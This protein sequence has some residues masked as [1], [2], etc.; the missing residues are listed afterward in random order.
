MTKVK[1]RVKLWTIYAAAVVIII[2]LLSGCTFAG[3][4]DIAGGTS[5]N[6]LYIQDVSGTVGANFTDLEDCPDSYTGHGGKVVSVKSK[7]DGLE[8]TV[9]SSGDMLKST[10]DINTDDIVDN[11]EKLEGSTKSEVQT[12]SPQSHDTTHE[13]G[14]SDEID[15]TGLDGIPE[16]IDT[17]DAWFIPIVNGTEDDVVMMR[18]IIF[19]M[20]WENC[21]YFGHWDTTITGSASITDAGYNLLHMVTGT[22]AY[23]TARACGAKLGWFNF[24]GQNLL[25]QCKF[26]NDAPSSNAQ[27]WMKLDFDNQGDPTGQSAG[28]RIDGTAIK[29][30]VYDGSLDVTDLSITWSGQ[31]LAI[32]VDGNAD[33]V[34][35]YVSGNLEHTES[36]PT[37]TRVGTMR[38][39]LDVDN[40][41][42]TTNNAFRCYNS[43]WLRNSYINPD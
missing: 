22:T 17:S 1:K 39:V 36:S 21:V 43:K 8:F 16:I 18:P 25:W 28:F 3:D 40:N 42:D 15:I 29:A 35:F 38:F 7:E 6:P 31:T 41:E 13:N 34:Y 12:H 32:L 37:G 14:G 24:E 23:S 2:A 27:R 26:W 19:N 11:S 20:D 5:Q 10:Y 9:G 4:S 30:F 33:E